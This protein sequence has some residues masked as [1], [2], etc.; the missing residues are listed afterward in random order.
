MQGSDI[1]TFLGFFAAGLLVNLTPCVYPMLTVSASLFKPKK[2]SQESLAHSFAKAL[3]YFLGIVLMYS[4]LG[5][6]AASGGQFFGAALQ[7][8]WVLG[9]VAL[10]MFALGLSMF[11]VYQLSLPVDL[12]N[13]VASW[14]KANYFGLFISGLLV[15]VFAAPCIGPPVIALLTTVA[16]KGNPTFGLSAFFVFACGLGLPY[17]LLGTFS[18]LIN[19]IPKGGNWLLWIE[20]SFGIVLFGFAAF[21]FSLSLSLSQITPWVWPV[22]LILGGIYI[23]FIEHHRGER[24]LLVNLKHATASVAILAGLVLVAGLLNGQKEKIVWQPYSERAVSQAI[25]EDMPMLIDFYADWCINCHELEAMVFS[26]KKVVE[27]AKEFITL[28][29]DATNTGDPKVDTLITKY[30]LIGLP[31]IIFLNKKGQ[32]IKKLRV[33]GV[34]SAAKFI[35][36]LEDLEKIQ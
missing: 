6:A 21:Y 20:H 23:G 17:L 16:D 31:T 3:A 8:S 5:Y 27:K 25:N 14:R 10:L 24:K 19:K 29:V 22:T 1:L 33:E 15:G 13:K 18:S 32:E 30:D 4:A 11:G 35:K 9:L 2:D 36:R 26:N 12:L 7:N 34:V 28:R